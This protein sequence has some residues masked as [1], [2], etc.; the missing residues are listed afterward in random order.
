MYKSTLK[1]YLDDL[2]GNKPAPGGGSAAALTAAT[3]VSL[4]GMV[5]N[6]SI[7]KEKYKSFENEAKEILSSSQALNEELLKL[8]DDDVR[9]Y[10]KLARA[11]KLPKESADEK[12]KRTAAIQQGLKD[13]LVAPVDVCKC[14]HEAIKLCL[15]LAHQGNVN[16]ITDTGIAA[17]TL[18]CAFESAMYN[19]EINLN[20]IKDEKFILEV[21]ELL[22]PMEEELVTVNEEVKS[23]VERHLRKD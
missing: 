15:P 13:A 2:A 7:G 23:E 3:G 10:E 8:V 1:K 5:A 21:R 20:G 14:S 12:R 16:L 18:K 11:F 17:I 6:F 22:E 4:I 19:V 9:G